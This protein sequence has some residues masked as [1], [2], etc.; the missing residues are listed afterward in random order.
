MESTVSAEVE[1]ARNT[2]IQTNGIRVNQASFDKISSRQLM[3]E[4]WAGLGAIAA[5]GM[6]LDLKL[7]IFTRN[8][9]S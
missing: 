2:L 7:N 5:F 9:N 4:S 1:F 3:I 8:A 6:A